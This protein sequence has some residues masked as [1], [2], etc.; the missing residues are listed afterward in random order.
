MSRLSGKI[1][2]PLAV[3]QEPNDQFRQARP[4]PPSLVVSGTVGEFRDDDYYLL[5]VLDAPV[6]FTIRREE[7]SASIHVTDG[8]NDF[9]LVETG[10]VGEWTVDIPAMTQLALRLSGLGEP[11]RVSVHIPGQEPAPPVPPLR[12]TLDL[13]PAA[14]TIAAYDPHTQQIPAELTIGNPGLVNQEV[15]LDAA[16]SHF[17]WRVDLPAGPVIV[18]AADHV[19]VP[20]T[21]WAGPDAWAG[22]PVR[23]TVRARDRQG[24]QVTAFVE[25]TPSVDAAPV[26]PGRPW[27]VPDALAGGLD[28]ASLAL[29]AQVVP[30]LDPDGEAR[31]HDG[32]AQPNDVLSVHPGSLPLELTVDLAGDAAVPVAGIV[33]NPQGADSST[34]QGLVRQFEL[35]LSADGTTFTT[36]LAGELAPIAIDQPFVLPEPVSA[37]AARLRIL[38]TWGSDPGN[39]GEVALGEWKVIARPGVVP[40]SALQINLADPAMGGHVV[41]LDPVTPDPSFAT[42]ML[43]EGTDRLTQPVAGQASWVIGFEDDRAAQ[44]TELQWIDPDGSV[45]EERFER[46]TLAVSTESPVGPWQELGTWT[47]R[48]AADGAVEPFVLDAPVWARFV[49]FVASDLAEASHFME[50]PAV[51]R[52]F[53]RATDDTYRSVTGEWGQDTPFGPYELLQSPATAQTT[54][55][56]GQNETQQDA[57]PLRLENPVSDSAQIGRDVDWY[58]IEVPPDQNV[59]E[60]T[61]TGEPTV[62]VTVSLVDEAGNAVPLTATGASSP[63]EATYRAEVQPGERYYVRVEQPPPSVVLSF[64]TSASLANFQ[65]LVFGAMGAFASGVVPGEAF[66]NIMPFEE[67][68]LLPDWSD[69]PY[70]LQGALLSYS[71]RSGSSSA[72][73]TLLTATEALAGRPG[74]KAIVLVTDAE[75]S[76]YAQTAELWSLLAT[77]QPQIF[78]VHIGA[79]LDPAWQQDLMQDWALVA[80]GYYAYA[81]LQGEIDQSFARAATRLRHPAS[82]SLSVAAAA[83]EPTATPSPEPTPTATPTPTPVSTPTP[84]PTPAP[85]LLRVVP[86]R[87]Q[88]GEPSTAPPLAAG[89][90][91]ELILDTSGS[92]LE[93]I[94]PGVTR[95]E[96]AKNALAGLVRETLPAGVPV[97]LRVFGEEQDSC[98]TRLAVPLQPLD[99][100]GMAQTIEGI[101][102]VNL[103]NT[104]L[105]ASL[106]AVAEDLRDVEGPKIVVLVTDGEET[107]GGDPRGAIEALVAQGID[108]H[109][110]IV[111]FALDDEQL[112]QQF[113]QWARIGRGQYIDAGNADELNAAIQRAVAPPYRVIDEAGNIV[114]TG[115]VGGSSV[116]VPPGVYTVEVLTEPVQRYEGIV[117]QPGERTTVRL[118]SPES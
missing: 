90:A 78:T 37:T 6:T 4:L 45:P 112:K 84:T 2:S 69:Q 19:T 86:P 71:S 106:Q 85:G 67:P 66:A 113:Q 105:G 72:E 48:R 80:G 3:D 27:S 15:T 42:A 97:A 36:V 29:G 24:S 20:V 96:V 51:I 77:V 101:Q 55:E 9:P 68:F 11:Y 102:L 111:G 25:I 74:V 87:A 17:G 70:L 10:R 76:S 81:R 88:A 114:A 46:V 58:L 14:T 89:V 109:V 62:G 57:T 38:S 61:I 28:V 43:A 33:L 18:R 59:L 16:I 5:P 8:V 56:R 31:L 39:P 40:D 54:G 23:V 94:E 1:R 34:P 35:A 50:Y 115:V 21:I 47:L 75:T 49:R 98:D 95:I 79:G 65:P 53:E 91:V 83:S 116:R 60:L 107:C 7:G 73:A 30:V 63:R 82:Y 64:D 41:W 52:I 13:A 99:P 12:L 117:I 22:R 44:I 103:A 104:P 32:V 108:V 118:Q 110:N 100:E 92:M 26:D 93:E